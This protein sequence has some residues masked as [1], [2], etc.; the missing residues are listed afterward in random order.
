ML[1]D[2]MEHFGLSRSLRQVGYFAT[3]HHHQILKDL[4][5]ATR[6]VGL[7]TLTGAVGSGKTVLLGRMPNQF[8]SEVTLSHRLMTARKVIGDNGRT[9]R[10]IKTM[11]GR[12]YRFIAP[13]RERAHEIPGDTGAVR[14]G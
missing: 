10:L 14:S 4:K 13:L 8:I 2:V 12:G 1:S 6:E 3:D 7:I 5:V 11:H 9:Q